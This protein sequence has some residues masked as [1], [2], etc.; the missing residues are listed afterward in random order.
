[1]AESGYLSNESEESVAKNKAPTAHAHQAP[2]R[3]P[4]P[5]LRI[6]HLSRIH[7]IHQMISLQAALKGFYRKQKR[8]HLK[9]FCQAYYMLV[10][11]K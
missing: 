7:S 3:M 9:I 10:Q 5:P 8:K 4:G 1:M 6:A 2:L 11:Y